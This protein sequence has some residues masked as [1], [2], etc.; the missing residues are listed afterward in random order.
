M[1]P[2]LIRLKLAQELDLM[3][4]AQ[5]TPPYECVNP[6]WSTDMKKILY[7]LP[8]VEDNSDCADVI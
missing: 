8:I 6:K 3:L 7:G 2:Y 1:N 5:D 4:R